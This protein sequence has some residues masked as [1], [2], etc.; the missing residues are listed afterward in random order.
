MLKL[1]SEYRVD[2]NI[3]TQPM[4]D[5]QEEDANDLVGEDDVQAQMLQELVQ[6]RKAE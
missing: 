2:A 6:Q 1:L 4:Y 3:G 5:A